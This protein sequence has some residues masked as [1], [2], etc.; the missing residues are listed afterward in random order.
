[1]W[2][3]WLPYNLTTKTSLCRAYKL[4]GSSEKLLQSL[5]HKRCVFHSWSIRPA[6]RYYCLHFKR[7]TI[8]C[9]LSWMDHCKHYCYQKW[10]FNMTYV[11]NMYSCAWFVT[12][13][14]SLILCNQNL[15]RL[16]MPKF[17]GVHKWVQRDNHEFYFVALLLHACGL[18]PFEIQPGT[19]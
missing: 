19:D 5:S 9:I 3:L 11:N 15:S 1:M 17:R 8:G 10:E 4:D 14:G 2:V 18:L 12:Q 6:Q 13:Q 16:H 7:T